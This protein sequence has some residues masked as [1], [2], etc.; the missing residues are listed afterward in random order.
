MNRSNLTRAAQ[1][2]PNF[3]FCFFPYVALSWGFAERFVRHKRHRH[4]LAQPGQTLVY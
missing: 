3:E 4:Q 1:F 2:E